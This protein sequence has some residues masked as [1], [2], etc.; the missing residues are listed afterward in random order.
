VSL[1]NFLDRSEP[2]LWTAKFGVKKLE[3]SPYHVVHKIFDILNHV[4]MNHQCDRQTDR[5][6]D[7]QTDERTELW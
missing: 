2:S 7:R 6:T 1:L 4:G 5:R 3:A